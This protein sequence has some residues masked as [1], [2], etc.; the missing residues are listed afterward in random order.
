MPAERGRHSR[1]ISHSKHQMAANAKENIKQGRGIR[2]VRRRLSPGAPESRATD[3][4]PVRLGSVSGQDAASKGRPIQAALA[5]LST[6]GAQNHE[7]GQWPRDP[8]APLLYTPKRT[9]HTCPH[10]NLHVNIHGSTIHSG[11]KVE[12]IQ[13]SPWIKR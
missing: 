3:R 2:S 4:R 7:G 6:S 5:T 9:E 1:E 10:S 8:T 12:R 13:C 11:Q